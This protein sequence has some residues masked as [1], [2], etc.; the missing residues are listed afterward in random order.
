MVSGIRSPGE[1]GHAP[2]GRRT[3]RP[4]RAPAAAGRIPARARRRN[5]TARTSR[6]AAPAAGACPTPARRWCC[7]AIEGGRRG[8]GE[9]LE[10]PAPAARGPGSTGT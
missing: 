6:L 8:G 3:R 1:I 2:P 9:A 5:R 10:A 7:A 4:G